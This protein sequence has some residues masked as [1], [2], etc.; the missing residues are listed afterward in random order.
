[1]PIWRY[2]SQGDVELTDSE[3]VG[4][5]ETERCC[6]F[7]CTRSHLILPSSRWHPLGSVHLTNRQ[8]QALEFGKDFVDATG[9]ILN[10]QYMGQD[11]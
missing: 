6:H 3:S 11:N 7:W 2:D 1:M 8:K 4:S 9:G 10:S 5:A